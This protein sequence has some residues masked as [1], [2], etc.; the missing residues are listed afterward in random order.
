MQAEFILRRHEVCGFLRT[1]ESNFIEESKTRFP[2]LLTKSN[3]FSSTHINQTSLAIRQTRRRINCQRDIKLTMNKVKCADL[4]ISF[5]IILND[6][7]R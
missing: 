2:M 6:V 3:T 5:K 7:S 1:V 4:L